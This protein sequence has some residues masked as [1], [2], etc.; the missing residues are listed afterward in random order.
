MNPDERT[1]MQHVVTICPRHRIGA[2]LSGPR[3]TV[4][5]SVC[6]RIGN[7]RPAL[8]GWTKLQAERIARTHPEEMMRP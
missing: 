4:T 5:C 7:P 2:V 3:Y 8:V 1:N 6:G